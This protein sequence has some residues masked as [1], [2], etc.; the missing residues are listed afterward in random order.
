MLPKHNNNNN[1]TKQVT[2]VG[3]ISPVSRTQL[4]PI[5][6]PPTRSLHA[7]I[8]PRPPPENV[9]SQLLF[10]ILVGHLCA[11]AF[12]SFLFSFPLDLTLKFTTTCFCIVKH[13]YML[14]T[15][16]LNCNFYTSHSRIPC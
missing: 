8:K 5:V 13:F 12:Q 11:M 9:Q 3:P 16:F 1:N 4:Q 2:Q 6:L 14:L 7:E 10:F 15:Y